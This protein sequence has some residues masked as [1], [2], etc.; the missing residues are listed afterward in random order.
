LPAEPLRLAK[1]EHDKKQCPGKPSQENQQLWDSTWI[2]TPEQY[3]RFKDRQWKK[4]PVSNGILL[5]GKKESV[6]QTSWRRI[7]ETIFPGTEAAR[8]RIREMKDVMDKVKNR[9]PGVMLQ[10]QSDFQA[11]SADSMQPAW[12]KASP[13]SL[14]TDESQLSIIFSEETHFGTLP[15]SHVWSQSGGDEQHQPYPAELDRLQALVPSFLQMPEGRDEHQA[16]ESVVEGEYVLD[17]IPPEVLWHF[18]FSQ[19]QEGTGK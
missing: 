5:D 19:Q 12:P 17:P 2:M 3:G 7:R 18:S 4:T 15:S 16:P 10:L 1:E 14:P 8:E 9:P 6:P 13:P 11:P